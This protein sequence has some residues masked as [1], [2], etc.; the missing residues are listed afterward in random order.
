MSAP[1]SQAKQI[2]RDAAVMQTL[3]KEMGVTAYEPRVVNQMLEYAYRY[4]TG[5]V[6]EAKVYSS[7]AK[8][9]TV[10]KEDV[11]LAVEML[12]EKTVSCVPPREVRYPSKD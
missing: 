5:V 6:E 9:K 10:D 2:P 11:S 4:V 3:L 1:H 12:T 7:Y 8:K